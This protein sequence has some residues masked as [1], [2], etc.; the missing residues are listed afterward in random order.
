MYFLTIIAF[1]FLAF[2]LCVVVLVQEGK[3]GGLGTAFGGGDTSDSLFGTATPDILKKITGYLATGFI[4]FCIV[5]SLWTQ[6]LSRH[7]VRTALPQETQETIVPED[8]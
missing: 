2:L 8:N 1:I 4:L 5:L 6:S 7:Q 3:A